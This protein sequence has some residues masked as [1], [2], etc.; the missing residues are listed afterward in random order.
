MLGGGASFSLSG[1]ID[2]STEPTIRRHLLPAATEGA[3]VRL[4]IREVTFIDSTGL[5]LLIQVLHGVGEGGRLIISGA[6]PFVLRL[7][8]VSGLQRHPRLVIEDDA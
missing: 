8:G 7:L 1:E 4:D 2:L 6:Q 3:E 5:N